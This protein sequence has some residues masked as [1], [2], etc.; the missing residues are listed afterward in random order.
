LAGTNGAKRSSRQAQGF[1]GCFFLSD[2]Q[3]S[4]VGNDIEDNKYDFEKPKERVNGHVEGLAGDVKPFTV[5]TVH[6][7]LERQNHRG[8][9]DK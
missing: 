2:D 9:E 7:I 8:R 4:H 6:K 3:Q 1:V 5:H